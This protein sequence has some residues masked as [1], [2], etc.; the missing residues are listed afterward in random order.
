[1]SK[2]ISVYGNNSVMDD[3]LD[4]NDAALHV[5]HDDMPDMND[6]M[7]ADNIRVDDIAGGHHHTQP[8]TILMQ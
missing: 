3:T 7:S 5:D 2:A 4:G 8:A 6:N 1:M